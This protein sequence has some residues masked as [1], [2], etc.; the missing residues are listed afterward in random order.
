VEVRAYL[1]TAEHERGGDGFANTSASTRHDGGRVLGVEE[2]GGD[3]LAV[4]GSHGRWDCRSR[5]VRV[6]GLHLYSI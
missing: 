2:R 3:V 1:G 6:D 5:R 4:V